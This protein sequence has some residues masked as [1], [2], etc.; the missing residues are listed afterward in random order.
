M[1]G[2]KMRK[3]GDVLN[4]GRLLMLNLLR[5]RPASERSELVEE[6]KRAERVSRR[7]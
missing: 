5:S 3:E 2:W 6:E 4:V 7:G 1:N